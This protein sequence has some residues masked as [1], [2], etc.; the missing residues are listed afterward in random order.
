[1]V[2]ACFHKYIFHMQQTIGF[3]SCTS[4]DLRDELIWAEGVV[5][6]AI[7]AWI[8]LGDMVYLDDPSVNCALVPTRWDC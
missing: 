7:D 6:S 1:M 8:W 2:S 4:Y 5:P 3:G